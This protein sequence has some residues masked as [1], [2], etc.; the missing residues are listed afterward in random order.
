MSAVDVSDHTVSAGSGTHGHS[1]P[2]VTSAAWHRSRGHLLVCPSCDVALC[3]H[4][5]VW[6]HPCLC[7]LGPSPF[8][9]WAIQERRC[10]LQPQSWQCD[11][12]SVTIKGV[13]AEL[14][15]E[16]R[17]SAT[18]R[19]CKFHRRVVCEDCVASGPESRCEFFY[20]DN[21]TLSSLPNAHPLLR[22]Q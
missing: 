7:S 3:I 21:D 20:I 16:D 10:F 13:A 12:C 18:F 5:R 1:V 9:S 19:D 6:G 8:Q 4:C 17:G 15:A 14:L 2:D 22:C 11:S